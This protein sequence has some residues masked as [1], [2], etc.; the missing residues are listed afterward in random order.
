M[1]KGCTADT[2]SL[3]YNDTQALADAFSAHGDRIAVVD[4]DR[5]F[6]YRQ[7][8][9]RCRHLAGGLA[10]L[11]GGRPVAEGAPGVPWA[12]DLP[13]DGSTGGFYRDGRPVPW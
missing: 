12:V 7:L 11:A 3:R 6:S 13:D 5:R 1:P 10:P 9:E 2:L 8:H 4:G